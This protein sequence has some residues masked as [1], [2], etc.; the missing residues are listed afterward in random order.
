[1]VLAGVRRIYEELQSLYMRVNIFPPVNR[2]M[3]KNKL[4]YIFHILI[5]IFSLLQVATAENV[6][7]AKPAETCDLSVIKIANQQRRHFVQKKYIEGLK[8]PLIAKGYI[9]LNS[10]NQLELEM[11]DPEQYKLIFTPEKLYIS[12][13]NDDGSNSKRAFNNEEADQLSNFMLSLL[14]KGKEGDTLDIL[15]SYNL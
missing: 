9:Y 3:K 2:L 4:I 15:N 1:M 7:P 13:M 12:K 8:D 6:V 10:K 14:G 11:V 5:L